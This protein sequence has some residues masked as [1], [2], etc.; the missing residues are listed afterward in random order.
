MSEKYGL[1]LTIASQQDGGP[2]IFK[3]DG[4]IVRFLSVD[5]AVEA[6]RA[7]SEIPDLWIKD[8]I[9]DIVPMNRQGGYGH[10]IESYAS[11]PFRKTV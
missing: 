3:D 8:W 9:Y 11:E 5:E 4:D 6:A 2:S 7:H 10:A 1:L